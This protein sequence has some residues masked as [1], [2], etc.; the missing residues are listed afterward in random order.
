MKHQIREDGYERIAN[1]EAFEAGIGS[2]AG[3]VLVG[4]LCWGSV[5]EP[6]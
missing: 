1:A 4:E 6:T 3:L 5:S 2:V